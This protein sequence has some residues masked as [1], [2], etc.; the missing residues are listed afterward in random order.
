MCAVKTFFGREREAGGQSCALC[1][2]RMGM[3]QLK[4]RN[5]TPSFRE[6]SKSGLS[7]EIED[8]SYC[9]GAAEVSLL[10]FFSFFALC[11]FAFFS[12]LPLDID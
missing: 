6:S 9:C 4:K 10:A 12:F 3:A 1:E 7:V 11:V 5:R 8:R 2:L